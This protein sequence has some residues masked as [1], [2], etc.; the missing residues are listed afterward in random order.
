MPQGHS[1]ETMELK[2]LFLSEGNAAPAR[3]IPA[4]HPMRCIDL[5][6]TG[7][8]NR[9][10][11]SLKTRSA[12]R[13]YVFRRRPLRSYSRSATGMSKKHDTRQSCDGGFPCVQLPALVITR[14]HDE[15]QAITYS[16][17]LT[18]HESRQAIP[19]VCPVISKVALSICG[20]GFYHVHILK[21]RLLRRQITCLHR[22]GAS[23]VFYE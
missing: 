2:L 13:D 11:L 20:A 19:G 23:R 4:E 1:H 18:P 8:A 6:V 14:L 21:T 12:L 10:G 3:G 7:A 17:R 15:R 5:G 9:G 22:L 16:S